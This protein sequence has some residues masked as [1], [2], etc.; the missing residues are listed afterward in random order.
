MP[1]YPYPVAPNNPAELLSYYSLKFIDKLLQ[2][3]AA[4]IVALVLVILGYF[5]A[6]LIEWLVKWGV[7][8]LRIN[9]ALKTLGFE[10]WLERANIELKTENFLGALA[11]DILGLS[12]VNDFI[13]RAIN[14]LPVALVG[15]LIFVISVFLAEF[16]RKLSFVWFKGLELK[17]AKLASEIVFYAVAIFGLIAALNHLGVAR[18]ILNIVVG[19]VILAFALGVGLSLGLGGQDLAREF[20]NKIKEKLE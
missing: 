10:R 9:E 4:F 18:D 17:G 15:G 6:K 11:F 8:K 7:E 3:I 1:T 12:N 13:Y 2:F 20:L 19:G 14:Y 5:I 16:L